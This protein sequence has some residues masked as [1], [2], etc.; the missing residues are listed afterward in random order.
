M[1]P[2]GPAR[3]VVL[4]LPALVAA[5]AQ[6]ADLKQ[7][8]ARGTLRVLVSADESPEIFSFEPHTQPGFEREILEGFTRLRR[9]KL[10]VAKA[11]QFEE[12]IPSL[13]RD[14]ADLATGIVDTEA[15]RK[16]VAFTVEILPSRIL[17]VGC[18]PTPPPDPSRLGG[19]RVGTIQGTSWAETAIAAG[20][21]GANIDT[22]AN[23]PALLAALKGHKVSVI[24]L[25]LSDFVLLRRADRELRAGPF[26]G[27]PRSAAWAVRREDEEL[28]KALNEYIENLRRTASWGRMAVGYFGDEALALLGRAQKQ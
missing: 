23:T 19:E 8:E 15:R 17:L 10:E 9:L 2:L 13:L 3:W 4:L 1:L 26:L 24:L 7:V 16:Q 21:P 12:V 27:V 5:V 22:F 25:S 11:A 28:R 14:Q 20:V 6:G 18:G